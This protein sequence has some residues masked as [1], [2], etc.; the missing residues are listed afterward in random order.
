MWPL[1]A[2]REISALTRVQFY[3]RKIRTGKQKHAHGA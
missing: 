3:V 2:V 1:D